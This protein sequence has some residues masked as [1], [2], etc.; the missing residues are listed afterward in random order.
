[1][2]VTAAPAIPP[3]ADAAPLELTAAEDDEWL[4]DEPEPAPRPRC[5]PPPKSGHAE[6]DF[7]LARQHIVTTMK[8]LDVASISVAVARDGEILWEEGFG[9]P[10]PRRR[11]KADEH[12]MYSLASISK[13]FT[14]TGM[15]VLVER[16]ELDLGTPIGEVLP[17]PGL[18]PG[19]GDPAEATLSRV[20]SH[21][22][23]LP[24]HHQFF[25]ADR[26]P[27]VPSLEQ[28]RRDYAVTVA[29]PG[30]RYQYSNLGFGLLGQV[31][32]H[33]SG[34]P[35]AEFMKQE[36]FEPLDLHH[37]FVGEP[38]RRT[39]LV[40]PRLGENGRP[41][42][43]YGFDHDGA[44]AVYSSAHDLVRFGMFHI[45]TE[46]SEQQAILSM[47]SRRAMQRPV[48]PADNY[49]L[50]WGLGHDDGVRRVSHGGGMPGV[51]TAIQAFP[52]QGVVIVVLINTM[53]VGREHVEI[54]ELIQHALGLP[55]RSDSVCMLPLGHELLGTWKGVVHTVQ[56]ERP[57][58]LELRET[59]E[60]TARFGDDPP[61]LVRRVKLLDGALVGKTVGDVEAELGRGEP[62]QLRLELWLRDGVLEGGVSTTVPWVSTTTLHA[63]LRPV[64]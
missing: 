46:R 2:T 52:E 34:R 6:P 54:A 18:R 9:T 15:M 11:T 40:A 3:P 61:Q 60:V 4:A 45:G 30:A 24:L 27:K 23:G 21:T 39:G 49:G 43:S 17:P 5:E 50:G 26:D 14:A 58:E 13:P 33:V 12:T 55:S 22:S 44:S 63:E 62:T 28:T 1:M 57:M 19:V 7:S 20:A 38:P 56:G 35:Y 41:L 37:T 29:E 36:V 25:Y 16:G 8:W 32:E 31:I 10:D 51:R 64:K 47:D 42:P 48:A 53:G 59:G